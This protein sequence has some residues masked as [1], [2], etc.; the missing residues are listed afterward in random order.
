MIK[1]KNDGAYR[2][3]SGITCKEMDAKYYDHNES[4]DFKN[5]SFP[6]PSSVKEYVKLRYSDWNKPS[7]TWDSN[8]DD[9]ARITL[10]K[11]K[12][13]KRKSRILK[14]HQVKK[15]YL[16]GKYLK[17][18]ESVLIEITNILEQHQIRYW[19]DFGTLLGIY[20]DQA[21]IPWDNDADISIHSED[22]KKLLKI[23]RQL[24]FKYRLSPRYNSSKFL[25]GRYRVFKL[26]YWQ[27]KPLRLIKRKELYIDIFV[28][29]KVDNYYY[30]IGSGTP[31]RVNARYHDQLD[32]IIWKREKF[33]IPSNTDQYLREL[34]GNWKTPK[35]EFD[36][37][38]EEHTICDTIQYR[39]QC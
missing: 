5:R 12:T 9:G 24:P 14:S 33:Y 4:I 26:K 8:F 3:V 34:Y 21:L 37:S 18:T 17:Q 27:Q 36:S 16:T 1:V 10:K 7:L 13:L 6:I 2:W 28:K 22:V 29:Y 25:P 20:R 38:W 39:D 35:R 15:N 32:S 23:Q 31:K 30:W 19:L 11:V